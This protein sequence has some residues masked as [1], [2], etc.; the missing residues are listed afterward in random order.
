MVWRAAGLRCCMCG[1]QQEPLLG[2]GHWGTLA[3]ESRGPCAE[4]GKADTETTWSAQEDTSHW[5]E[6]PGSSDHLS[7][8]SGFLLASGW[9]WHVQ[10]SIDLTEAG[11]R[12]S[13]THI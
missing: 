6:P 2:P 9:S 3:G 7:H 10:P 1:G 8:R 5:P 12:E 13:V 11:H 4:R